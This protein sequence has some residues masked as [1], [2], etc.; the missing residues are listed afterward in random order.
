MQIKDKSLNLDVQGQGCT[1]DCYVAGHWE[2]KAS[3]STTGCVYYS[4]SYTGKGNIF[5]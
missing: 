3:P 2:L 4:P 1:D 5:W